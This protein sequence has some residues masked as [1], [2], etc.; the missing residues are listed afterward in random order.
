MNKVLMLMFVMT[1]AAGCSSKGLYQ[2]GQQYGQ[3]KCVETA[4]T[5]WQLEECKE[6]ESK[7]FEE[8]ERMKREIKADQEKRKKSEQIKP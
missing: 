4:E 7:S 5:V 1:L 6:R 2:F 3:S 8:Y